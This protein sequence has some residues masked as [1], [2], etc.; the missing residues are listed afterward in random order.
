MCE[1]I[2]PCEY[3]PKECP[4]LPKE[5]PR[6]FT[7]LLLYCWQ[8]EYDKRPYRQF[9]FKRL[10]FE[11]R[12]G[13]KYHCIRDLRVIVNYLLRRPQLSVNISSL[14]VSNWD[15]GLLKDFI[16]A[17]IPVWYIDLTLM[18]FPH[19][20]FVM[21]RLNAG[22]LNV[23]HLSLQGTP[24]T[25]NDVRILREFLL[26]S[27]TLRKLNV[28]RC[29]LTQYNFALIADGVYKSPGVRRLNASRLLG[30]GL[31]LD[32]EKMA[33]ILG[34]LLMQN[35]LWSLTL[36]H[37]ELTAQDM[38]P[39]AEYLALPD[40]RFRRL[41]IACNKIG[42]DGVFF[43]MRGMS[44]GGYLEL[45]DIRYCSIGTHGG[46]WVAKY[47]T[48]CRKLQSLHLNYNEIGSEAVNLILLAMKKR[49]KLE[50]L[51]L[52]GN[53]FDSRTAMIVR[54]LLDAEVVLHSELDI[55]YTYDEALQD[56]RVVPWR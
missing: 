50:R 37:C 8:R 49:C 4:S 19:E 32:S 6:L 45:L 55:S 52:Y 54:R 23:S 10:E 21:M 14:V 22:K 3:N 24:L 40:S 12:I 16:R 29:S 25:D 42:P 27:K 38:I 30:K 9:Q 46:E 56:Y 11:E 41:R 1:V 43:L 31:T 15:A 18:N 13:R 5:K 51:T 26:V 34:S 44:L 36:E 33:S 7:N 35:T 2:L 53:T 28:S 20:F 17:L 47:L 39:I 48:S